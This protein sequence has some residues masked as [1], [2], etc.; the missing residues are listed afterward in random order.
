MHF[1]WLEKFWNNSGRENQIYPS[2]NFMFWVI[3][4]WNFQNIR[5]YLIL[6][7]YGFYFKNY[8]YELLFWNTEFTGWNCTVR[9]SSK[10][11][12]IYLLLRDVDLGS[13]WSS[14]SEF[15]IVEI[16]KI[17]IGQ[18]PYPLNFLLWSSSNYLERLVRFRG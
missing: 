8:L 9:N 14:G 2:P 4:S 10:V 12:K 11:V 18:Q 15:L 3:R 6:G 16:P 13:L 1:W 5:P 17:C 7:T